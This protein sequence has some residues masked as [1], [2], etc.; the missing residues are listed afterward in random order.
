LI[1]GSVALVITVQQATAKPVP[2]DAAYAPA[3]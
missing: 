1:I 3:D 2:V